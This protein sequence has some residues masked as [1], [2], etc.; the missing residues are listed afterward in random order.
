MLAKDEQNENIG[1]HFNGVHSFIKQAILGGG[2]VLV[3]CFSGLNLS[4]AFV[5]A[6]LIKERKCSAKKSIKI[7]NRAQK[8]PRPIPGFM[9]QLEN[10]E[11][12]VGA[13][14]KR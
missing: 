14:R 1:R 2:V 8:I 5:I 9:F 12:I 4:P 6:Y 11:L 13:E 7:I 10:Y 3:H